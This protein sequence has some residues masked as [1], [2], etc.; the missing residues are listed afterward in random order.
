VPTIPVLV[1][2][3][4]KGSQRVNFVKESY[5]LH[6]YE[7]VHISKLRALWEKSSVYKLLRGGFILIQDSNILS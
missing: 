1:Q 4:T 7:F 3:H 5:A 6:A 2:S